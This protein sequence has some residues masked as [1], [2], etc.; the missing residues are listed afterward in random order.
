[1][2]NFVYLILFIS[3]W[4]FGCFLFENVLSLKGSWLMVAGYLSG[5]FA[6]HISRYAKI[7]LDGY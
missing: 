4:V 6:N 3:I 7:I 2:G 5:T 1:M